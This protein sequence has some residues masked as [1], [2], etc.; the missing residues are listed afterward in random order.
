[1]AGIDEFLKERRKFYNRRLL[2]NPAA[3]VANHNREVKPRK[4]AEHVDP[5]AVDWTDTKDRHLFFVGE[6]ALGIAAEEPYLISWPVQNGQLN[7]AA[8]SSEAVLRADLETIWG[9]VI[10][11]QLKIAKR[12]LP[13]W[14]CPPPHSQ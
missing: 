7:I 11:E 1:L 14:I 5:V 13:V 10:E 3:A 8:Y 6:K 9:T 12:D 4:I 2:G